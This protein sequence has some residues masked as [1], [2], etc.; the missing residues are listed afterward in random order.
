PP[1]LGKNNI[2]H[3]GGIAM[4]DR[5]LE[6]EKYAKWKKD[7]DKRLDPRTGWMGITDKYWMAVLI[8]PAAEKINPEF[9][10]GAVDGVNVYAASYLGQPVSIAPGQARSH[11]TRFFAGPKVRTLLNSYPDVPRFE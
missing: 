8:P 5:H 1:E 2:V 6:E 7:G 4:L 3:E 11:T 10:A 9:R